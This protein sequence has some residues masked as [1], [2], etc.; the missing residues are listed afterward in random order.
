MPFKKGKSPKDLANKINAKVNEV[1]GE[2]V[3]KALT[4]VAFAIGGAADF[5]VP[6]DTN[7]LMN[8]RATSV[9]ASGNGYQAKITYGTDYAAALHGTAN[10]SPLWKPKPAGTPG[11]K[12][13]GYNPDAKPGWIFRGVADTDVD[14]IFKKAMMQ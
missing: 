11:K 12:T 1:S 5:Y 6:V 10:Y 13:G 8:S 3:E 14:G 2:K 7:A 9:I 4:T